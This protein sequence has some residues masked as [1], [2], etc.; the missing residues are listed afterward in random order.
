MIFA[1]ELAEEEVPLPEAR[2]IAVPPNK[3]T[4]QTATIAA[5]ST[6]FRPRLGNK[7]GVIRIHYS[8]GA[9]RRNIAMAS[10]STSNS[11]RHKIAWIPVEAGR[12]SSPC[13]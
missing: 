2:R 6:F 3:I 7:L 8:C 5:G 1:S 11:G 10:I 4:A 9:T 12:G 13:S